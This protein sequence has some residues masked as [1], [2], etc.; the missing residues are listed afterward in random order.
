[1]LQ[2]LGETL[3]EVLNRCLKEGRFP[4]EWKQAEVAWIPKPGGTGVRP[5]CLLPTIGKVY[6]K[7]LA[8]RLSYYLEAKGLLSGR[9]FEFQR[10]RGTTEAI[11]KAAGGIKRAREEGKHAVLVALDLRNAFNSAWYPRLNQLLARSGCPGNLGQAIS[12]FLRDRSVTSEGATVKTE[13]GCPQGSCLGPILWLL[14]MEEWFKEVDK[15]VAPG[16]VTVEIQAFADDQL[17][18]ITGPSMRGLEEAWEAVWAACQRWAATHKLEY[19][20]EKTTAV[21][22]PS[23]RRGKKREDRG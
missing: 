11:S 21:F 13:R 18:T 4:K 20:P 15:L 6:D 7:I 22:A 16:N 19:A 12:D 1:L 3:A 9:Q 23:W 2:A 17:I 8:T 5:V 10:G 14:V